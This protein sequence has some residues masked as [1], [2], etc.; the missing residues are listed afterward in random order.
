MATIILMKMYQKASFRQ[1][2]IAKSFK[3]LQIIPNAARTAPKSHPRLPK[4][5]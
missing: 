4:P 5:G 1:V 3:M 2:F